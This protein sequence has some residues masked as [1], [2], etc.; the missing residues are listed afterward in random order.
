MMALKDEQEILMCAAD[1]MNEIFTAESMLLR[2]KKLTLQNGEDATS[3][4]RDM[5]AVYFTDSIDR[6]NKQGRTAIAS[7]ASGDELR[8]MLLG[9][10]RF[11]KYR[12]VNTTAA[13]RRIADKMIAEN[14]YCF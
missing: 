4:H 1:M 12:T 13:R 2:I 6:L 14:G 11:T 5:L 8:M 7:F 3:I 10:K 9:M